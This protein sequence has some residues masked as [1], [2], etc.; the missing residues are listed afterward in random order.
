MKP[1]VD[2]RVFILR[3]DGGE[4]YVI[5]DVKTLARIEAKINELAGKSD[6]IIAKHLLRIV[7]PDKY[8][9]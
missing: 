9:T 2:D 1:S 5:D 4:V 6:K 7:N 8:P 3:G